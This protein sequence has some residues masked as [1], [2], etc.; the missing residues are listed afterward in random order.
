MTVSLLAA[1]VAAM[2][3]LTWNSLGLPSFSPRSLGALLN[4]Y[5]VMFAGL[6]AF[7][8]WVFVF[9]RHRGG[10]YFLSSRMLL[11][12]YAAIL[13]GSM[14]AS[15]IELGF[16][17]RIDFTRLADWQFALYVGLFAGPALAWLGIYFKTRGYVRDAK[18]ANTRQKMNS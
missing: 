18:M 11:S 12:I 2:T 15:A 7:I 1:L 3:V 14:A 8:G 9:S 16:L 5:L 10:T 17:H 4:A 6:L 13:G